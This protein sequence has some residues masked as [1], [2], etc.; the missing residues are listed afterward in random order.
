ML[1]VDR[2]AFIKMSAPKSDSFVRT[3]LTVGA[4]KAGKFFTTEKN[5]ERME[6]FWL[7]FRAAIVKNIPD[8]LQGHGEKLKLLVITAESG[9][10][11]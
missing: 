5:R 4:A 2:G 3:V 9:F 10:L 7:V 6:G 8:H 1:N 11:I